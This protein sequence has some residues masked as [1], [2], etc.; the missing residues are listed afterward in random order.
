M[1]RERAVLI[2]GRP[3]FLALAWQV[4]RLRYTGFAPPKLDLPP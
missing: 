4:K 3:R 1:V 2:G